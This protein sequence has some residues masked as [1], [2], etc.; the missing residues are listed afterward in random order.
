[1]LDRLLYAAHIVQVTGE[2][3]CLE[4]REPVMPQGAEPAA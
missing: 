2:R 4:K 3:Y 1:M